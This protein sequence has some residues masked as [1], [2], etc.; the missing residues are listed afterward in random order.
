VDAVEQH[1]ATLD[2]GGDQRIVEI[3]GQGARVLVGVAKRVGGDIG[4]ADGEVTVA[5][6]PPGKVEHPRKLVH[7]DMTGRGIDRPEL[8]LIPGHVGEHPAAQLRRQERS[9]LIPGRRHVRSASSER[10]GEP[11]GQV[12]RA[13]AG[14]QNDRSGWRRRCRSRRWR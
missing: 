4:R 12:V 1:E 2:R 13:L 5:I 9:Q 3:S 7:R 8:S 11:V 14:A 10:S 6:A